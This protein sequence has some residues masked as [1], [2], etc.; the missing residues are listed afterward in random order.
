MQKRKFIGRKAE[1]EAL[2]SRYEQSGF[3]MAVVY[4]RR[5]VGK[6]EL[7]NHFIQQQRCRTVSFV[8]VERTESELLDLMG[9]TV[10]SALAP[11]LLN[12]VHFDSFESIFDFI[13]KAARQERIIF[14]IDEYPYLAQ[15]CRYMNSLIQKYVDHAWKDSRLYLI[16]C[17]SLVSFMRDDV[18]G[19]DA[20]LHGRSSL[21]M[22]LRP[23]DYYEAAEFLPE[24]SFED[25]AIVYGLTSGVAKYLE[26]FDPARTLEENI[27][28]QF[29]TST[30]Y[31]TEEQIKTII[32]G[33]RQNSAAYNSI[34]SAIANGHTKY[35]EITSAVGMDD[36]TYYLKMLTES[37]LIE[38]RLS[39]NRPYYAV[40]DGMINF[41]FRY[42]SRA[43]SL[44]NAGRGEVYYREL[45]KDHLHDFMGKVFEEMAK[46]YIFRNVGTDRI[47]VFVSEI[48]DYQVSAKGS[49]GRIRQIE[50]DLLGRENSRIVL[51]GECKFKNQKFGREDLENLMDKIGYLPVHDPAVMIF[52]L[53][54]FTEYVLKSRK[55]AELVR[56]EDMY[57]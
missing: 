8:S 48:S 25:K 3:Q 19:R 30:G 53:S 29:F 24:Y 18:I 47:P 41:W 16:L 43:A 52:S 56:I 9:S 22:K 46:Q 17:G 2:Q 31:F 6:T 36:A 33:D 32:T 34:I 49:D 14:F 51:T 42:V 20:P 10:L 54:G 11:E 7:I 26:Q 21:E 23:F 55:K 57:R 13:A 37:E 15:Q 5:R 44:V 12:A 38:K 45:V 40:T 4:G 39:S 27:I 1:L 35:N 50:L 28:R